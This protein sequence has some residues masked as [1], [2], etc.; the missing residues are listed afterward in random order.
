MRSGIQSL[1]FAALFVSGL[2]L[3]LSGQQRLVLWAHLLIGLGLLVFLVPWLT[4]HVPTSLRQSRRRAFTNLSWALLACWTLLLGSGLVMAVP[5]L[6]WLGGIVWFP[7]RP[8]TEALSLIHFWSSWLAAGG[9]VLHLTMRHWV[10]GR[11]WN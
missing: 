7:Q 8:V 3:W 10:W 6:L 5:A 2:D 1:A 11:K 4:R 9:L